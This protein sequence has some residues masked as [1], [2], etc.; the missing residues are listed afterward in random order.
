MGEVSMIHP[1]LPLDAITDLPPRTGGSRTR[2]SMIAW[3]AVAFGASIPLSVAAANIL[4]GLLVLAWLTGGTVRADVRAAWR[5]PVVRAAIV[6]LAVLAAGALYGQGALAARWN[7]MGK[8]LD[9]L[10]LLPLLPA[11]ADPTV[12]RRAGTAL[13]GALVL[14]LA[15]SWLIALGVLPRDPTWFKAVPG[16]ASVFKDHIT[17]SILMAFAAF[18]WTERALA[19][20]TVRRRLMNGVLAGAAVIDILFFVE[21]R[22]GYVILLVLA[23]YLFTVRYSWRGVVLALTMLTV[24]VA[25]AYRFGPS[26]RLRVNQAVHEVAD[27]RPDRAHKTP[28]GLRLDFYENSL[29][30]IRRHPWVGVGTGGFVRAYAR[31]A[32]RF[33]MEVTN[34]PHDQFLLVWIETGLPGLAAL[35]ALFVVQWRAAR[36]LAPRE[37]LIARGLLCTLVVGCLLNSLLIDY[38]ERMFYVF[39]TALFFRASAESRPG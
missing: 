24:L 10:L 21:G 25:G 9:L 28:V 18:V 37:R 3:L 14:T 4:A 15:L 27:W 11:F 30:I 16:D 34:N 38:T 31:E 17:Q 2:R 36:A 1:P 29:R 32:A 8:Y 19:Q 35:I 5:H 33:H 6:L 26:F 23:L 20:G 39:G 13:S 22:T 12:A 7:M